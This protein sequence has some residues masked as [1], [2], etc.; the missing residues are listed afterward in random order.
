MPPITMSGNATFNMFSYL[1]NGASSLA[2]TAKEYDPGSNYCRISA[3][4][5]SAFAMEAHLNHLGEFKLS[6]W[7]IVEPKLSWRGKLDLIVQQLGVTPD[8]GKRPFQTLGDLFKFRDRLAHGKTTIDAISYQYH[9]TRDEDFESLD[10]DWLKRFWTDDAVE[11]V[12][13][14]TREIIELLHS[15]AGFETHS[16]HLI[17]CGEFSETDS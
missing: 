1:L 17:G 5:L 6:F 8:F 13:R 12:L 7:E 3:V 9:G 14:D 4:A 11:R 2:K 15:A 16:I 10:P